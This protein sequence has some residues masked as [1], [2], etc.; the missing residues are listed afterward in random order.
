MEFLLNHDVVREQG[1]LYFC[2]KMKL[3]VD[4]KQIFWKLHDLSLLFYMI[5][6]RSEKYLSQQ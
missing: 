2:T 4:N 1:F 6:K 3:N 5:F